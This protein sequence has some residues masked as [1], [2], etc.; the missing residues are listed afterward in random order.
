[1][2][3]DL[4]PAPKSDHTQVNA[5]AIF[6]ITHCNVSPELAGERALEVLNLAG[7][8]LAALATP[9]P[10]TTPRLVDAALI[11][12]LNGEELEAAEPAALLGALRHRLTSHFTSLL[13]PPSDGEVALEIDALDLLERAFERDGR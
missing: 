8:D 13:N 1:M 12:S 10:R 9:P 11:S 2:A 5:V 4:V 7:Y 6:L 3:S